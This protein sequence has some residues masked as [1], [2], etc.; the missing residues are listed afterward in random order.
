MKN[1]VITPVILILA[2]GP[3]ACGSSQDKT[4][5]IE[6]VPVLT[7]NMP[8]VTEAGDSVVIEVTCGT[9]TPCWDFHQFEITQSDSEYSIIVFAQYDGRPCIQIPGTL[10]AKTVIRPARPGRYLFRFNQTDEKVLT[11]TMAVQ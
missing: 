4:L 1:S 3:L 8:Q 2:F 11:K 6:T 10:T 7:V 9:P 5:T